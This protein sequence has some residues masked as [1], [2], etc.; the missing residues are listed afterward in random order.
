M[1]LWT[2]HLASHS[3]S[4]SHSSHS[5]HEVSGTVLAGESV[6]EM[7]CSLPGGVHNLV[8]ETDIYITNMLGIM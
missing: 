6:V 1:W 2:G 8:E 7:P 3:F 4:F 5:L